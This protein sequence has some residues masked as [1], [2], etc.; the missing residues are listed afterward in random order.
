VEDTFQF[1]PSITIGK[2]SVSELIAMEAAIRSNHVGAKSVANFGKS[3]LA[4]F[5]DLAGEKVGIHDRNA[6]IAKHRGRSGFSH[7]HAASET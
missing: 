4:G 3:G 1:L 2:D 5:D 7:A 6:T